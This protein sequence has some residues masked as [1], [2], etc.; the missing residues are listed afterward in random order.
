MTCAT[1]RAD[2]SMNAVIAFGCSGTQLCNTVLGANNTLTTDFTQ[3][4]QNDQIISDAV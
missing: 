4:F 3:A 2:K 1:E